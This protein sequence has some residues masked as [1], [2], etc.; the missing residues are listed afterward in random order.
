MTSGPLSRCG[1]IRQ[2]AYLVRDLDAAV[3]WW[4]ALGVGPFLAMAEARMQGYRLRGEPVEPV[5]T[6]AFANSADLQIELI[7]THDDVPSVFAEA[8][9]A[10]RDGAH[11]L[12]WWVDDW[13]VWEGLAAEAGW[14]PV[15][16]GD[17]GGMAHFAYYDLG[18]PLLAEVMELNDSTRWLAATVRAAHDT[19]DGTE[20][21]RPLF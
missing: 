20:P 12:A 10:G 16:D 7:A 5:L 6:L 11:H 9:A 21:L 17:G 1:P 2:C 15:T 19:W 3:A 8:L 18:G 14:A 4:A 13:A